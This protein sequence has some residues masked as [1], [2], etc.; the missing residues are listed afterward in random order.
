MKQIIAVN[1]RKTFMQSAE[2]KLD[3]FLDAGGKTKQILFIVI[4]G[5]A[6]LLD[7]LNVN[8]LPFSLSWIAVVLCG[9]P[10]VLEAVTGLA[11]FDVKADLLV[12]IAII[13]SL[14][15]GEYFAAGE[16]AFIMQIGSFLEELTVSKAKAGIEKIVKLTPVTARVLKNG[17]ESEVHADS[18]AVDDMLRV[19]PGEIVPVDGIIV[20]G[21]TSIDQ[22][23]ITGESMPV[24]KNAGSEVQS[25]TL[26]L[27]GAFTMQATHVGENSSIQRVIRLVQS[28][29]AEKAKIVRLADK[30]ATWII[31]IAIASAAGTWL[32]TGEIIRS[33]TILVVFCPCAFVLATPT[34][35][36]AAIG[37]LTKFGVLVKEGYALERLAVVKA[38][39]FDKT[40]T[41]TLGKPEVVSVKSLH[42]EMSDKELFKLS[43]SAEALSEHPIGKAVTG[44]YKKACS[45]PLL[46]CADFKMLAGHGISV[47]FA[48]GNIFL[49]NR[50]LMKKFGAD[51]SGAEETADFEKKGCTVIFCAKENKL[52]GR[53]M[54]SDTIRPDAPSVIAFLK[55][56]GLYTIMLTGD[57]E[58]SA[59]FTAKRAGIDEVHT[60]CLPEDKLEIIDKL[61]KNGM[62]VCMIGDG[63]ND[64]PALKKAFLGI[65]M[66]GIG[67]DIAIEAADIAL[68]TDN[69]S[70]LPY[71]ITLAKKMMKTIKLNMGLSLAIN[72]AAIL[73]AMA[74]L[75]GPVAGALIH[76]G[77]SIVV[78]ANS[79]LLL[80][81]G[82]LKNLK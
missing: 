11:H 60:N 53:L 15:I 57:N 50:D 24:D 40:G 71:M 73:M 81:S 7:F 5:I 36:M 43:A 63:V 55:K 23:A 46:S 65:A 29:D 64:A 74:G 12:A 39:A 19:L 13:A 80:F 66:G 68:A 8:I 67:S 1:S 75:L 41:V 42:P 35:I 2:E 69:I 61:Q 56:K 31:A 33:V 27:F 70:V 59:G 28:A 34:A 44:S 82:R 20:E 26:N 17:V 76:N 72:F 49:G 6:L 54:L 30:W 52:L 37:N 22:S 9:L 47:S 78:I 48:G 18:V 3:A 79:A 45:E 77:G 21:A 14:T 62:Q 16:V 25:G 38:I 4:S 32:V 51:M 58:K 10:I